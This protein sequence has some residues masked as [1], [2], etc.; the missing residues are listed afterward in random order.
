MDFSRVTFP[1]DREEVL[2]PDQELPVVL[3]A[4]ALNNQYNEHRQTL[5][6]G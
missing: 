3:I 2:D 4:L 6:W 5:I 1:S